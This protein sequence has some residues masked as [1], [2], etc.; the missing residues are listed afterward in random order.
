MACLDTCFLIDLAGRSARGRKRAEKKLDELVARQERLT[1]TRFCVAELY[2]GVARSRDPEAEARGVEALIRDIEIME[3]DDRAAQLFGQI[4]A[5]L[6]VIGRP[7]GDMDVL[8]A[9][10]AMAA[11]HAV[12]T[13]NRSHF[14][15]IPYL[16]IEE[17]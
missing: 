7:T 11:G 5:H 12:V 15:D 2:V 13:R 9:A 3:F 8:I 6:Q 4:T 17:Y 1:T 10:T 14:E 16:T